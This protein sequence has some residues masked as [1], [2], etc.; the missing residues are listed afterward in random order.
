MNCKIFILKGVQHKTLHDELA[1]EIGM[2][3]V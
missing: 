1:D 2:T 3:D